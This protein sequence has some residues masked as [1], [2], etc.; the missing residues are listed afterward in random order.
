MKVLDIECSFGHSFE[1][2]FGSEQ[3]FQEQL[4]TRMI[5]CP[6]CGDQALRKRLSAPRLNL[7]ASHTTEVAAPSDGA[8]QPASPQASAQQLQA[9]MLRAMR[10]MLRDA[11]DVGDRF[12]DEARRMHTGEIEPASIRGQATAQ[13][14]RELLA[15]GVPVLPLPD[16]LKE[17]LH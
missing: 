10:E 9:Q 13:Q 6:V 4:Q 14:A 11:V 3:D 7:G 12:A 1:G 16:I 15:E 17:P 5:Q 2:W 8:T